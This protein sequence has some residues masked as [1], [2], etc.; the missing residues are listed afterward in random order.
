MAFLASVFG[1]M[2]L[3]LIFIMAG[4][5]KVMNVAATQAFIEETTTLPGAT[6]TSG[7]PPPKV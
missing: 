5:T 4:M 3:A 1:R 2:F 7:S 6:V